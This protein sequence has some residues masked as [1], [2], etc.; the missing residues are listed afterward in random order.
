MWGIKPK[1]PGFK[2]TEIK[3]QLSNLTYSKIKVP[4]INGF[5]YAEYE[6]EK[7]KQTIYKIEIPDGMVAEF[8]L[9]ND[10]R[11][12]LHNYTKIKKKE[13]NLKL[14]SGLHIIKIFL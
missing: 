11:K 7:N 4:T 14:K 8:I 1:T 13:L 5:I 6:V 10:V 9:P 12:V 3:P 2:T